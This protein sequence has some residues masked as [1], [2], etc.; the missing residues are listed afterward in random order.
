MRVIDAA[1]QF[2]T[3]KAQAMVDIPTWIGQYEKPLADGLDEAAAVALA[4]KA[5]I[6]SQRGGQGKDSTRC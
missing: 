5:V 6:S 4:E 2:M 3:S 1:L